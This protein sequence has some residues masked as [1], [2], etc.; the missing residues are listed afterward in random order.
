MDIENQSL[1]HSDQLGFEKGQVILKP[2]KILK[3]PVTV[4]KWPRL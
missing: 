2:N 1:S 3:R 4:S